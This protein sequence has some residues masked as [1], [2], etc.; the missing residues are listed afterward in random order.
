[1]GLFDSI[2]PNVHENYVYSSHFVMDTMQDFEVIE[3]K[4]ITP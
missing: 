4:N 2:W 1:M 3:L